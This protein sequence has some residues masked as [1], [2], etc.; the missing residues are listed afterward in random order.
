VS[1]HRESQSR[2]R[3]GKKVTFYIPLKI[4]QIWTERSPIPREIE[5]ERSFPSSRAFFLSRKFQKRE[6][7]RRHPQGR[8]KLEKR[9]IHHRQHF[10]N[11]DDDTIY[12]KKNRSSRTMLSSMLKLSIARFICWYES[13]RGI[14]VVVD[15]DDFF[16]VLLLLLSSLVSW[17]VEAA[18][19]IFF[20]CVKS[21]FGKNWS[22][23]KPGAFE[24]ET[25][26][27][28]PSFFFS[29]RLVTLH[30]NW[31]FTKHA[32]QR[33]CEDD[34]KEKKRKTKKDVSSFFLNTRI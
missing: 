16:M 26:K 19:V 15:E 18:V 33:L 13:V 27:I 29:S 11:E 4:F 20:L 1:E 14:P 10:F 9:T 2:S 8:V 6:R 31:S 22:R 7:E 30:Q 28:F 34:G 17:G 23:E 32:H 12:I 3:L 24:F 5:E 25:L 21:F